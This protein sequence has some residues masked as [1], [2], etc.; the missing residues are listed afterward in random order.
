MRMNEVYF[1]GKPYRFEVVHGDG[2]PD[3]ILF[4]DGKAIYLLK[5]EE[6]DIRS[7]VSIILDKYYS[8]FSRA[9]V[10]AHAH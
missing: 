8:Q 5:E 1:R 4:E 7:R 2:S 6:L 3:F 9:G 10:L